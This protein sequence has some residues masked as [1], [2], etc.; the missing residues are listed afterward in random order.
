MYTWFYLYSYIYIRM[1]GFMFGKKSRKSGRKSLKGK[2]GK[3][4]KGTRRVKKG[5]IIIF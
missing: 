3:G 4:K 2:K 5:G 1:L